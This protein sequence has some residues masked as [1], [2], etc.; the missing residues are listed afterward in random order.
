[1]VMNRTRESNSAAKKQ[2]RLLVELDRADEVD[3]QHDERRVVGR[4]ARLRS[5]PRIAM[6]PGISMMMPSDRLTS[7]GVPQPSLAIGPIRN[8]PCCGGKNVRRSLMIRGALATT[9]CGNMTLLIAPVR[10]PST[11]ALRARIVAVEAEQPADAEQRE[12]EAELDAGAE[13]GGDDDQQREARAS[14]R[15]S[16]W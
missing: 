4:A 9:S 14:R 16:G 7:V 6:L 11:S 8:V 15:A 5:T 2:T 3:L 1:M 12:A 10:T 13:L